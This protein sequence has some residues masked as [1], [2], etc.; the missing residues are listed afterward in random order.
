M[1]TFLIIWAGQL[2]STL[3]SALTSFSLG[4]W[5]YETTGSPTLF[6]TSM[7]AWVLPN[8][9][10]SPVA[11]VLADRWDRRLVMIFSDTGAGLSSLFIIVMLFS[12]ELQV[13]HVYVA[14]FLNAAFTTFQWPAYTAATSQLV[15]KEHLGRAGGM[16]QIGDAISQ[17]AGPAIAGALFVAAGLKAVL[18]IDVATYLVALATL[19]V[20]RFP[21]PTKAAADEARGSFLKDAVYGW[22]VIRRMPGLFG[23]LTV[24]ATV[25]FLI[26]ISFALYTPLI[27]GLTTPDKLGYVNSIG[28]LG[29]LVGTLL[30]STWGGPKRRIY[31]IIAAEMMLGF[32]TFLFGLRLTI[33]L[34]AINNFAFMVAMPVSNGCSQAIWQTKVAHAVQGRVFAIRRVLA[35]SAMPLA[36]AV[37][38]PLA[39]RVFEPAMAEGGALASSLG[40]IIGTG[41]GHGIA[42]IFVLAGA[43]YMLAIL[44]IPLHPRIRRLELEIPDAQPDIK[45]EAAPQTA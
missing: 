40:P 11:G 9:L 16:T 31:G 6:A 25:N 17:L 43:L 15:P 44:V 8:L 13:W 26:N 37:A 35:F 10:L 3:G 19:L 41:P 23:L 28:G 29:M 2:V 21:K 22:T 36:Y 39:E 14:G 18:A 12:G 24:F 45:D 20:V 34:I 27:L 30:M 42:L 38:G 5:V 1:R 4:V 7:L 32:T 33:P